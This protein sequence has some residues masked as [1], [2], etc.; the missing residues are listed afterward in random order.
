MNTRTVWLPPQYDV[1]FAFDN[2]PVRQLRQ[3]EIEQEFEIVPYSRDRIHGEKLTASNLSIITL[4]WRSKFDQTPAVPILLTKDGNAPSTR[5]AP[6]KWVE[7]SSF[8]GSYDGARLKTQCERVL[9]SWVGQFIFAEETKYSDGRVGEGFRTPQ[10]GGL[11]AAIAHWKMS[12]EPATIVM[13]TGTGKTE[14]MLGVALHQRPARLMVI[15]PTDPLRTQISTKFLTLGLLKRLGICGP[16]ARFP[17]VGVLKHGMS[18]AS[19]LRSF[20]ECCNVVISTMSLLGGLNE[21]QQRMCAEMCSHLFVDEAHHIRAATWDRFRSFFVD[22]RVLQFT[23]TPYR[24]DGLHVDGRVIFNYPLRKAQEENYFTPI[25]LLPVHEFDPDLSNEAIA[26]AAVGQLDSDIKAGHDH[27]LMARASSTDEADRLLPIYQKLGA[28]FNPVVIHSK[29]KSG[30]RKSNLK[31]VQTRRSRIA[32]CVDM[33]GEGFDLPELKVAALHDTHKSL[34]ITLQFI[35]RFTRT[36][37]TLGEA[38]AIVNLADKRADDSLSELYAE[39]SNWSQVLRKLSE[40]ASGLHTEQQEFL[41][42]FN[43][44]NVRIPAQNLTPKMSTVVYRTQCAKWTPHRLLDMVPE[45]LRLGPVVV[46]ARRNVAYFITRTESDVEWGLVR[47][48]W[49]TAYDLYLLHWNVDL[50]LLFIHTSDN[51]SAYEDLAKVSCGDDVQQ[52]KGNEVFRVFSGLRRLLLQTV[53]L[54]HAIGRLIR[55]TMLVGAD[56]HPGLSEGSTRTKVTTNVFAS[57]FQTAEVVTVGCSRKGRIW[58]RR[59]SESVLEWVNWCKAVG[60]KLDDTS[61]SEADIIKNSIIPEEIETRPKLVPLAIEWPTSFY[62]MNDS[63]IH[64]WFQDREEPFHNVGLE[65]IVHDDKTP[66][67]FRIGNDNAT[68]TY[69][70]RYTREGAVYHLIDGTAVEIS[71]GKRRRLLSEWFRVH[72]PRVRFEQDAFTEDNQFCR[73]ANAQVKAFDPARIEVLPWTGIDL[74]SESQT[75][76]KLTNSIQRHV[77]ELLKA[78]SINYDIILDDDGS[79][80]AADIVALGI[81]DNALLIHLFHCKYSAKPTPGARVADLYEVCGQAQRSVQWRTNLE[82]LLTHLVRRD[83]DRVKG[84]GVTRFEK[85]DRK[86]LLKIQRR[87]R[88][89]TPECEVTIAQPGLSKGKV[90]DKQLELLGATEM[91]LLETFEMRLRVLASA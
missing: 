15:V 13:P 86:T 20:F 28:S 32:I 9:L 81:K 52:V 56:I 23:A 18:S 17:V 91:Y 50:K 25:Q 58:S 74:K 51:S 80:E 69:E 16:Q 57:G 36:K 49:N 42:E 59:A 83:V 2:N 21:Q 71:L 88:M 29:L 40:H 48:F 5:D 73:P 65:L 14:T 3:S 68:S 37:G 38:T 61:F 85:G 31:D 46:N 8:I 78:S 19:R 75:V 76:A 67:Q 10:S 62:G 4:P 41:E 64:V 66:I 27:I 22:R 89:L 79:G 30:L 82:Q 53:G 24:N 54:N 47:E 11:H 6:A 45:E 87:I 84:G 60:T 33:F 1:D 90:T 26:V 55:F 34:A 43:A 70:L 35:G 77:I 7:D 72:P 12:E 63:S 44:E 39:G